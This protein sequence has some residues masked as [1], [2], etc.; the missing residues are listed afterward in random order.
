M[1]PVKKAPEITL[2]AQD[3]LTLTRW[4]RGR[5]TPVRLMQRAKLVLLAA[6]GKMNKDIADGW[7]STPTPSCA[8]GRGLPTGV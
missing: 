5:S 3:R 7:G 1:K 8:G 4:S 6:E 2:T